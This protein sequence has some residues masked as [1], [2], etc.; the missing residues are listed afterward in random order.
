MHGKRHAVRVSSFL[1]A[2]FVVVSFIP[3]VMGWLGR[4]Y[5]A[6]FVPMDL[7]LLYL[8]IKLLKS[9]TVQEGR[10]EIR[11]LY[12]IVTFSVVVL[13]LSAP[14]EKTRKWKGTLNE[15]SGGRIEVDLQT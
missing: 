7:V 5:L 4:I 15:L 11:R 8:T 9:Q 2:L 10:V 13:S 1:F 14:F 6:V 3:F 12:L